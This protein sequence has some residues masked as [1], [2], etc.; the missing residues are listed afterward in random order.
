MWDESHSACEVFCNFKTLKK[1]KRNARRI[2]NPFY[3]KF[4]SVPR[5][6]SQGVCRDAF[7]RLSGQDRNRMAC[8]CSE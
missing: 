2:K 3:W 4:T 6:I 8:Y 5:R 1:K 7:S